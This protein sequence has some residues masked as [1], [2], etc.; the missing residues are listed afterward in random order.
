MSD[1]ACMGEEYKIAKDEPGYVSYSWN[2][3]VR[4]MESVSQ[5]V[6]EQSGA[7]NLDGLVHRYGR[8]VARVG[9][10]MRMEDSRHT[11]ADS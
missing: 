7:Y 9:E 4:R 3:V 11:G 1:E 8:L 6:R 10:V 2:G 5:L